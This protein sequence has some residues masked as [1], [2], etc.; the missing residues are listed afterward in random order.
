MTKNNI[1]IPLKTFTLFYAIISI[2]YCLVFITAEFWGSPMAG[3]QGFMTLFMQWIVI[4]L[5]ASSV[6]GLMTIN[7]WVFAI[8]YPI[9]IIL[10][11]IAAYYKITLGASITPAVIE[12]AVINN[13]TTWLTLVSPLLIVI[14]VISIIISVVIVAYR[15][16]YVHRPKYPL[17]WIGVY[18]LG[19]VL[20]IIIPRL[21]APVVARMPY[22]FL[23]S[24]KDWHENRKIISNNR[25]T[26]VN[27]P[28]SCHEDSLTVIFVIGESLRPDHL[29]INGY[30]RPTT[31]FLNADTAVISIS[32][33]RTIPYYTHVSVPHIMTRADSI[34]PNI[35]TDEQSFITLF[36]KARF[37]TAWLSN[38][39]ET[40]SYSYFMHEA[41]EL[42][43]I[44]AAKTFYD[45][46]LQL[47]ED[48]LPVFDTF[49]KRTEPRKLAVIH[50][51]GSHWWY[52][53]HYKPEDAMFKPEINSR[54]V[55]ELSTEQMVNSY[56][57]TI[58]AT[59]K[60]L[61]KIINRL[62]NL[63]AI[64]IYISDHG[65]A[66]GEN[67]HF[68]HG[69]DYPELHNTASFVWYSSKYAQKHWK[70]ILHLKEN[71]K[72]YYMTDIMFHST[73]DAANIATPVL[74][75]GMSIFK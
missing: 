24:F 38:Q 51:I 9:L 34:H 32:N 27:T 13:T 10:S 31:P 18:V 28:V 48:L 42:Q 5:A 23:W 55:S 39:D 53:S 2:I 12:L 50:T 19:A 75:Y 3:F 37:Y 63:N 1:A 66:L 26:F 54:I 47:D 21:R 56:D 60:F 33:M 52:K 20:P 70:S 36:K 44:N 43:R 25:D 6:I 17:I 72:N 67:G 59:D 30:I 62:R 68:L 45:F 40:Q 4:S 29:Q 71:S 57:N 8:L 11:S 61:H 74:D 58:V 35:A 49:I 14:V 46:S 15:F 7:K 65:E 73:L 64:L 16:K 41:D 69:E 22:S